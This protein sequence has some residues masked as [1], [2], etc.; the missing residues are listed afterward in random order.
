MFFEVLGI[1]IGF[2]CAM[3][4]LSLIVTALVQFIQSILGLRTKN[5]RR[6]LEAILSKDDFK[7]FGN[8]SEVAEK[9][10]E[11]PLPDTGAIDKLLQ[12][13]VT[14]ID[15][16]YLAHKLKGYDGQSK[17]NI[18]IPAKIE[19]F[20]KEFQHLEDYLRNRFL[21]HMRYV[22]VICAFFVAFFFQVNAPDLIKDLSSSP[23]LRANYETVAN[24]LVGDTT[25][26]AA[27]AP[28]Y[29][30]AAAQGL[31]KLQLRHPE[32][33][34]QIEEASGVGDDRAEI[35]AELDRILQA[36]QISNKAAILNEY[37]KM[38]DSIY[39]VSAKDAFNRTRE[40]TRQLAMFNIT[41]WPEGWKYYG[42][43]SNILG[44][45][46]TIIL[47]SF[48]APFWFQMLSDLVKLKDITK[49]VKDATTGEN[50]VTK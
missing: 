33:T 5:L 31:E 45:L 14:W 10:L 28:T 29:T 9:I 15:T 49:K 40:Y 19:D 24:Q 36:A 8:A 47:L 37:D 48:G 23:E 34:R 22:T 16:E 38:L 26:I 46:V 3:L 6:G 7:G 11:N 18:N 20:K 39:T 41:I 21:L 32:I 2:V 4:L 13:K 35:V 1:A 44:V 43:L 12:P 25:I 42:K 30:K 17:G 50:A 27:V